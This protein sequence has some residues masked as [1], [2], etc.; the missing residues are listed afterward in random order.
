MSFCQE[1]VVSFG[2]PKDAQVFV[3]ASTVYGRGRI[4]IS[5]KPDRELSVSQLQK[6]EVA[7]R[8]DRSSLDDQDGEENEYAD[9]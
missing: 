1:I 9:D 8:S 6:A 7:D 5:E 3:V 4:W 2:V